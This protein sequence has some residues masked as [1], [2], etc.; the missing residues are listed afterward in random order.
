M[1]N[2][3]QYL[4]SQ[5]QMKE[6]YKLQKIWHLNRHN[7]QF[8]V[9]LAYIQNISSTKRLYTKR[10]NKKTLLNKNIILTIIL[11]LNSYVKLL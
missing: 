9:F 6:I 5:I 11:L 10:L 8:I 2:I 1:P 4:P 3:V 7:V